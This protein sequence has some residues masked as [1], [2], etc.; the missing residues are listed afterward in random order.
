MR[1]PVPPAY[2]NHAYYKFYTYLNKEG[3][4]GGWNRTRIIEEI[5]NEGIP[6]Y[7]G[8]CSEIY[9]ESAFINAG[10]K[11]NERLPIAK[12]LGESSIMFLVHPTLLKRDLN[13]MGTVMEHVFNKATM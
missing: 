11:S 10:F 13:K 3:L 7:E 9:K 4:K 8:S 6:C 5:C 12:E 1:T 2:S